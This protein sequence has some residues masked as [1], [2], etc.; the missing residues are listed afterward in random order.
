MAPTALVS[1][2]NVGDKIR[3][4]GS[5]NN[6]IE[7]TKVLEVAQQFS[8]APVINALSVNSPQQVA[9]EVRVLE[10]SRSIGRDLGVNWVGRSSNGNVSTTG[11]RVQVGTTVEE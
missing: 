6:A 2:S 1:V 5:V 3:L 7:L 8:E 11:S 9:L 4:S 10:A